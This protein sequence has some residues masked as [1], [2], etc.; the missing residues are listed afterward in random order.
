MKAVTKKKVN[1][2]IKNAV[3]KRETSVFLKN[4]QDAKKSGDEKEAQVAIST[5][6]S[7]KKS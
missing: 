2:I 4:L 1:T 7:W 5:Y 3:A 6:N